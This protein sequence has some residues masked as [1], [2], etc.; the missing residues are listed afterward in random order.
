M[1]Q[2]E[3]L[4]QMCREVLADTD[5]K[6]ICKN[7]GLPGQAATSRVMLE[8]LFLS[9]T[10]VAHAMRS[11]DRGEIALLH[12]LANQ[13]KPV[14]ITFFSRLDPPRSDRWMY[15]TFTQRFG[16]LFTR[17]KDHLV[18]AGILLLALGPETLAKKTKMERWQFALPVQFARHLPPL[19]ESARHLSGEGDWR[20]DVG[21]ENLK[22][23]LT[24]TPNT[25]HQTPNTKH[26]SPSTSEAEIVNG[27]LRWGGQPFRADRVVEWRKLQWQAETKPAK[28]HHEAEAYTLPPAEAVLRILASL[29]DDLWSDADALAA[30][31]EIFCGCRVDAGSVCESGWRWGFLARQES[32]GRTWYRLAPPAAADV[33]PDRYLAVRGDEG[34]VVDLDAVPLEALEALVLL[35]DQGTLAGGQSRLLVTPNLVKLGRAAETSAALPLADWLQK[36]APAFAHAFETVRQRRGKTILHENLSVAHVSDLSLKV[37]LE[38]ALAG[39][40]VPLGEEFIAFP[41]GAVAEVKRLVAHLGHVV[42]EVHHRKP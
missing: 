5:V 37:A 2:T 35:S 7:R 41:S 38:K 22:T 11:L 42:K 31:L 19:L 30:P 4:H 1:N 34:V 26:K 15:G 12:L 25:K 40:I 9:D 21:R 10:G 17:V 6:A 36:N 16:G 18:R 29:G 13:D 23:A 39:R 28:R 14:D 20:N 24:A 33:P 3:M 32:E 27:E 8:A